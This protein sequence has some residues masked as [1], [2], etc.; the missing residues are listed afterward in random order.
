LNVHYLLVHHQHRRMFREMRG[1]ACWVKMT[2]VRLG[3]V[4]GKREP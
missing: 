1:L 4:Q 3:V 2:T